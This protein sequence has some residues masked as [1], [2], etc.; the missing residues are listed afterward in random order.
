MIIEI[1]GVQFIN[2]GAELMLQAVLQHINHQWP[3][4]KIVLA[5]SKNSSYSDRIKIGA[6][7][8]FN[9]RKGKLDLNR[10]SYYMPKRFRKFLMESYG[11]VTEVDVDVMLDASGFAYS[12]KWGSLVI[13][14]LASEII[15]FDSVEKKYIFL[16]QALGPFTKPDDLKLLRSS[17][18]KA[19]L[20]CAREDVSFSYIDSINS[21]KKNMKVFPDFTN[22]VQGILPEYYTG[23]EK[24]IVVIPNHNMINEKNEN[25]D[26]V[27]SYI[28]I[29]S[30]SIELIIKNGYI[31]VLLNHEGA[32]DGSI[33]TQVNE[34]FNGV[35]DIINEKD[36]LK[37]KGIIGASAAIICSRF[38]GCVSALC[39]G[40][41]CIGTSWSHKYE[42]LFNEYGRGEFLISP[43]ID[44]EELDS[45]LLECL[46]KKSKNYS[47]YVDKIVAFKNEVRTM[48][49]EIDNCLG[50]K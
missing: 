31:P 15:R 41:P 45:L 10:L 12:D 33:C 42:Q 21:N 46:D 6:L 49:M 48:W 13:K 11:I 35:I 47:E 23:G 14:H 27:H 20:I 16:P 43:H 26:W 3:D 40:V 18:P 7:Q 19:S 36:P 9:L 29:L 50:N 17:L 44:K 30:L 28:D 2:K 34:R 24:K 32:Q 4:S 22:L 25:K 5:P 37:V 39:Q 38:H 1:K 8:K